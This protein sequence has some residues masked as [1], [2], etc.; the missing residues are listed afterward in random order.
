MS[1]LDKDSMLDLLLYN[2]GYKNILKKT[3]KKLCDEE[4]LDLAQLINYFNEVKR[5][6]SIPLFIFCNKLNPM[7][8]ICKFLK[9]NKTLSN[10]EISVLLNRQEGSVWA[11][12]KR[13]KL[14]K[15]FVDKV[16][17]YNIPL[18]IFSDRSFSILESLV[19]YLY[20]VYGL[21]NKKI[22]AL[23]KRSPNSIAVLMKRA[24]DKHENK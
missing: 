15:K 16:D 4:K 10:K 18:S 24:K 5:D 19:F 3:L 22:S 1:N 9:E 11:S 12:Y 7:E 14:K 17:N 6:I 23:L 2:I 13:S 21:S 8:A 20:Q